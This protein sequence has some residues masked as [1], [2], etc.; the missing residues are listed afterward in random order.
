MN[1]KPI[2]FLDVDGV[3]HPF[4]GHMNLNQITT[5]HKDCMERLVRL[6]TETDSE[7]VLSTS[8][9]NFA[10]TRNRLQANL[11]EYGL[12]FQRWIE[13][14]SV[15]SS[16][17]ASS[18]KLSKILSFVQAHNPPEW[19]VL[20]DEDLVTLSG[21]PRDSTMVQLF[22]SRFVR[23]DSKTGMTDKD[24]SHSRSILIDS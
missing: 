11:A 24:A 21:L 23:T 17:S 3:L 2:I 14:D 8:W 15:A 12:S 5:F 16:G 22:E 10:S 6:V 4:H 19:A 20:D 9:R 18:G 7:L 1:G 13:P